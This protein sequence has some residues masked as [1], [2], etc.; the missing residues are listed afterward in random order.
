MK[1]KK[2]LNK[3]KQSQ[4]I[5]LTHQTCDLYNEMTQ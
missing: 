1:L 3:K 2:K 5:G 4:L